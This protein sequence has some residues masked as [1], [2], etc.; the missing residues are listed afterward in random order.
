MVEKPA[1]EVQTG[2]VVTLYDRRVTVTQV[3]RSPDGKVEISGHYTRIRKGI[4]VAFGM[5][6]KALPGDRALKIYNWR[7][8]ARS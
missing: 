1:R 7:K 5:T 8:F 2:H 6:A 3:L 4:P